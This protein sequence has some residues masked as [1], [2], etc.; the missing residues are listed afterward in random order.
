M[1][2]A[3]S[4]T[5][6]LEVAHKLDCRPVI[7]DQLLPFIESTQERCQ[8]AKRYNRHR[9]VIDVNFFII[10]MCPCVFFFVLKFYNH[11]FSYITRF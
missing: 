10:I 6:F 3:I 8:L 4:V 5:R 9:I 7:L 11:N 2:P 1:S